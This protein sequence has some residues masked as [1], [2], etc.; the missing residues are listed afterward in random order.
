MRVIAE[1]FEYIFRFCARCGAQGK[2][3]VKIYENTRYR[4]DSRARSLCGRSHIFRA[5]LR[6]KM[7]I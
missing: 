1:R 6:A 2:C 7:F 3:F 4:S 5:Q